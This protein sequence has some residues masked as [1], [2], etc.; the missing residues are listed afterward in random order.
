MK[1]RKGNHGKVSTFGAD[2]LNVLRIINPG[3]YVSVDTTPTEEDGYS[4]SEVERY[5]SIMTELALSRPSPED[6]VIVFDAWTKLSAQAKETLLV[7]S[8]PTEELSNLI[9][10]PKKKEMTAKSVRKYAEL[11]KYDVEHIMDELRYFARLYIRM[12]K[13]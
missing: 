13:T 7:L 8:F 3:N 5:N 9:G 4:V 6:R 11:Q 2:F 12:L 10:T 1:E